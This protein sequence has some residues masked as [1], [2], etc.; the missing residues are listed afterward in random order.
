LIHYLKHR[1][2]IGCLGCKISLKTETVS[3]KLFKTSFE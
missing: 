1:L 2:N 3:V